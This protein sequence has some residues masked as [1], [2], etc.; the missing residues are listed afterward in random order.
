LLEGS[1]QKSSDRIRITAQLI[2]ATRGENVWAQ[3][4]DRDLK[5]IFALQDEI[6]LKIQM[7]TVGMLIGGGDVSR[8]KMT[9]NVEAYLKLLK[10]F[11]LLAKN[12]A[13]NRLAQQMSEESIA[14][15]P[16]FADAYSLLSLALFDDVFKGWSQSPAKD[17]QRAFELAQKAIYL[18]PLLPGPHMTLGWIYLVQGMHDAAIAEGKKA[19][20][21]GPSNAFANCLLGAFLTWADRPDEAIPVINNAFR[22]NPFPI[23]WQFTAL[24]NAYLV[25]GRYEEALANHKKALERNPDNFF[26]SFFLASIYGHLGRGEEA[27]AAAKELLRLNPS[28]SVE[29]WVNWLGCKNKEKLALIVDGLRKA[30]L[31]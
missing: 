21:L 15:D 25:L 20:V 19:V 30:G 16:E 11:S 7:A 14:M 12:E 2:D 29:Q 24:G 6:T 3:T 4:Y 1:V 9:T 8:L 10:G 26:S 17:L 22:L 31:K 27:H 13:D 28:F 5:D 18:D 23:D